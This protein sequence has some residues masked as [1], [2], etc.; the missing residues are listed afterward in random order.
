MKAV[1]TII[2]FIVVAILAEI[3]VYAAFYILMSFIFWDIYKPYEHMEMP[4]EAL[5]MIFGTDILASIITYFIMQ[6]H[7]K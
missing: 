2:Q 4:P 1:K 6:L 5:R 7:K 3:I